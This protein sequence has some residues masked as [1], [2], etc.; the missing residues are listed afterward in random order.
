MFITQLY[1]SFPP[2][3]KIPKK[4]VQYQ[5]QQE[6]PQKNFWDFLSFYSHLWFRFDN[7]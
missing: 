1:P 6:I 2:G 7:L 5:K 4:G 3:D